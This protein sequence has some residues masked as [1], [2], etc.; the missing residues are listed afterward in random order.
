MENLIDKDGEKKTVIIGLSGGP[1]SFIA[2]YLLKI[3]KYDLIGVT[4][5]QKSNSDTKC[6]ISEDA[7]KKIKDFCLRLNI[8]HHT[9]EADEEYIEKVQNTWVSKKIEALP[10]PSSCT[11]CH[12][13][14]MR[15]LYLKMLELNGTHMSTGHFAKIFKGEYGV[16]VHS[17][18]DLSLD[19]SSIL[20]RL[21][22]E[23]LS[24]L[25][26]PLSSLG[27]V[28]MEKLIHNFS[29]AQKV[30]QS[31]TCFEGNSQGRLLEEFSHFIESEE[32]LA[33]EET[34]F[35]QEEIKLSHVL[36]SQEVDRSSPF[37]AFINTETQS[38]KVTV[39][40]KTLKSAWI[41]LS[42]PYRFIE[43]EELT[44]YNKKGG[45]SKLILTGI[46]EFMDSSRR[47]EAEALEFFF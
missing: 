14:R 28:E 18:H 31:V 24:S 47:E 32:V 12:Q 39:Y 40:P 7:L 17:N 8:P 27:K 21:P 1:S 42:A 5:L 37:V 29:L 25:I 4:I 9:V 38:I 43:G 46:I 36:W 3:Q 16:T 33:S 13:F 26:L 2:A 22:S 11:P 30:D 15:I 44:L 6:F 20:H 10:W 41:E 45:G 23:I 19:Q 34:N 35:S